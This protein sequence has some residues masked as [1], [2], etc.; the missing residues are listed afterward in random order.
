VATD[1]LLYFALE[2]IG[3]G[4]EDDPESTADLAEHLAEAVRRALP[5]APEVSGCFGWGGVAAALGWVVAS[6]LHVTIFQTCSYERGSICQC[7]GLVS[8]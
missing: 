1:G 6:V 2:L 3:L 4:N 8:C 5:G 7:W